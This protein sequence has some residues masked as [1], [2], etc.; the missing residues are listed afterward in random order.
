MKRSFKLSEFTS[1][2]DVAEWTATDPPDEIELKITA[3]SGFAPTVEGVALGALQQLAQRAAL[4]T[5]CSVDPAKAPKLFESLFGLSLALTSRAITALEGKDQKTA[6]ADRLW[7]AVLQAR[8]QIGTGNHVSIVFRDP[9]YWMPQCLRSPEGLFPKRDLF[10]SALAKAAAGMGFQRSFS[11]TEEDVITFLYEATQN[12]HY[13][14]RVGADGRAVAGVRGVLLDRVTINS[15]AELES[16]RDLSAFQRS[17][18]RKAISASSGPSIF[19]AFTV[20]DLGPGIHNTLPAAP[21]ES[22]WD[23]LIR[24]FSAGE[25]RKQRGVGLE[26]G[27]GLAKLHGSARR[28]GALLFVKSADLSGHIDFSIDCENYRMVQSDKRLGPIGTSL[29]LMW[30][31]NRTGGDQASLFE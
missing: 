3:T 24:A 6:T 4:T 27:Q 22:N 13:H 29:T 25:S 15:Q 26:A 2:D 23:R 18:I 11:N 30:P 17:Y 31:A 14:G 20:A 16:R 9:D 8:G 21:D 28:L 1:L 7:R 19:F 5:E 12:S 10:R